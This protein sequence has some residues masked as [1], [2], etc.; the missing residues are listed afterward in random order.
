MASEAKSPYLSKSKFLWGL[1]C[2]KLLWNAYNAKERIPPTDAQT[3]TIFDQGHEVGS[4]AKKLFPNGIEVGHGVDD[5]D[6]VVRLSQEAVKARRPVFEAA[7]S[8]Q[9][10]YARADILTVNL[11][12]ANCY[13]IAPSSQAANFRSR[14]GRRHAKGPGDQHRPQRRHLRSVL[15]Q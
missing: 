2:Q 9:G 1:Q 11:E 13:A 6:E 12:R 3:Q 14:V 8:Y 5:L 7:F 10:G 15:L 4:L